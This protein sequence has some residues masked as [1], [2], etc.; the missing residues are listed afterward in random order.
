MTARTRTDAW[1]YKQTDPSCL[2]LA[3]ASRSTRIISAVAPWSSTGIDKE[4]GCLTHGDLQVGH[5][6]VCV[7]RLLCERREL[8]SSS[9][10][11][12]SRWSDLTIWLSNGRGIFVHKMVLCSRNEYFN[13]L[14]GLESR[15]TVSI[16]KLRVSDLVTDTFTGERPGRDRAQGR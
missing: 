6:E 15:Y 1:T 5:S 12:S 7:R 16:A 14:C 3:L 9:W 10:Y 13:K 8:T 11:N 2:P 4:P